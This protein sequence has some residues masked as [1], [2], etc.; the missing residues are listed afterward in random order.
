MSNE[1]KRGPCDSWKAVYG[2]VLFCNVVCD[3]QRCFCHVIICFAV[4]KVA[5]NCQF[6]I[7]RVRAW[8]AVSVAALHKCVLMSE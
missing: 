7:P 1:R 4:C 3:C 6:T 5:N 8:C 2:C